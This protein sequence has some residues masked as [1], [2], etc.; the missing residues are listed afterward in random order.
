[1]DGA[2]RGGD[3]ARHLRMW[4][5]FYVLWL[6]VL[7]VGV[8]IGLRLWQSGVPVGM[9]LWALCLVVF[10]LSLCNTLLPL[11][12]TW[13]VMLLASDMVGLAAWPAVRIAACAAVTAL[14]TGIANLSEYYI[15]RCAL[16]G[17]LASRVR[18]AKALRR[19]VEWFN[20]QPFATLTLAAFVPIPVDAVRWLAI[21]AGYNPVKYFAAYFAGRVARYGLIAAGTVVVAAGVGTIAGVQA[22]LIVAAAVAFVLARLRAAR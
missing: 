1:V 11:P 8:V 9:K 15:L 17:R 2:L 6:T 4:L 20:V 18:Q 12:T 10:Y 7:T 5:G 21:A 3:A 13:A 14:A 19:G 22:V 16:T